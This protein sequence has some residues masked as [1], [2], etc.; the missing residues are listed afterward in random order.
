MAPQPAP[1][2]VVAT[3][4]LPE[5]PVV[6]ANGWTYA[7]VQVGNV[8]P[9]LCTNMG[10]TDWSFTVEGMPKDYR[11]H[12]GGHGIFGHGTTLPG[13]DR[14]LDD[15]GGWRDD[16][17]VAEVSI[18]S[19]GRFAQHA[20]CTD[21]QLLYDGTVLAVAPARDLADARA[22]LAAAPRDGLPTAHRIDRFDR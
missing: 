11:L 2:P 16:Y 6:S 1:T 18:S 5:L 20:L 3:L 19:H 10:G 14:V 15:A 12:G 21:K 17:Y 8:Y 13:G 4:P 22:M 9:E 7:I